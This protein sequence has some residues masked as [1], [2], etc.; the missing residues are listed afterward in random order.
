MTSPKL[1]SDCHRTDV[2]AKM[3]EPTPSEMKARNIP[4]KRAGE[5][6][7]HYFECNECHLPCNVIPLE[8]D[9][10]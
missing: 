8:G 5:F 10:E 3:R 1:G 9:Y 7:V 2:T 4:P 6:M